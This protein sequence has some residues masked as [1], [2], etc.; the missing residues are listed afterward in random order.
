MD[1]SEGT[2][3]HEP[4][5]S[6]GL[7]VPVEDVP[8]MQDTVLYAL[9]QMD[10]GEPLHLIAASH[11][12]Q[13]PELEI[14]ESLAAR[15]E[16]WAREAQDDP[17]DVTIHR[18]VVSTP[19]DEPAAYAELIAAYASEH[20]AEH[21]MLAP[22]VSPTGT[23]R[24]LEELTGYLER[25][26]L[27]ATV[28]P[29]PREQYHRPLT[30]PGTRTTFTLLFLAT[31]AFY[32]IIAELETLFSLL[33]GLAVAALVTLV[34]H[35]VT[36][37]RSPPLPRTLVTFARWIAYTPY[38]LWQI[39]KANLHVASLILHPKL[40]L[41]PR[42]DRYRSSLESDLARTTLANSITLTPGTLSVDVRGN[43]FY[44]HR[45]VPEATARD[46]AVAV[47]FVFQGRESL[48][49]EDPWTP[50][51]TDEVIGP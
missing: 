3:E 28:A 7:V 4:A 42:L 2:R 32:L 16:G 12:S 20:D 36:F 48:Q 51:A 39:I 35:R 50:L 34:F 33:T 22:S 29:P 18:R 21:V 26:G 8:A 41:D 9:A 43:I 40:P 30:V 44:V 13:P 49:R 23:D 1:A 31:L 14:A 17:E 38:L 24:V 6:G 45:L 37:S 19:R 5:P 46:L 11:G 10:P 15:A 25:Q 47:T 27:R